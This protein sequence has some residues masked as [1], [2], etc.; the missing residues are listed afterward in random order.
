MFQLHGP[1][2]ELERDNDNEDRNGDVTLVQYNTKQFSAEKA[3]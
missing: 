2:T 3:F 1:N